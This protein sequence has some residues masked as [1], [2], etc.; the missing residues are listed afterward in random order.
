MMPQVLDMSEMFQNCK[1][2]TSFG[3]DEF[4]FYEDGKTYIFSIKELERLQ[5]G[6]SN[7]KFKDKDIPRMRKITT[8][9]MKA[10]HPEDLL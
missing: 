9:F 1:S 3:P 10:F 5:R 7:F 2:L 8:A 6:C 4:R